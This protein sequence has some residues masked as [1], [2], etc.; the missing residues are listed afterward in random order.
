[1]KDNL[2]MEVVDK[3]LQRKAGKRLNVKT[4]GSNFWLFDNLIA[5]YV[6]E[7]LWIC[8]GNYRH[9]ASTA[10]YLNQMGAS[11]SLKKGQFYKNG[12]KWDGQWCPINHIPEEN[13]QQKQTLFEK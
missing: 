8:D 4:D 6:N 13:K 10:R 7:K 12:I 9:T 1:M 11:I 2:C 3:F 5:K